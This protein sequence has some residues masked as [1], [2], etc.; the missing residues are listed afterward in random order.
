MQHDA[1][2]HLDLHCLPKYRFRGSSI[3]RANIAIKIF[4]PN[5]KE[6]ILFLLG[7]L[8]VFWKLLGETLPIS[9]IRLLGQCKGGTS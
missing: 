6:N 7:N 3:Q 4:F 2:F 5:E 9:I 1:A 8:G